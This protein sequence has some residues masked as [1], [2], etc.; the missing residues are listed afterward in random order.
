MA[1]PDYCPI[2]GEPCQ[3]L[4]ATPCTTNARI[5]ELEDESNKFRAQVS[6]L[7][8][9]RLGRIAELEAE[10]D[11]LRVDAE[12]YRWLRTCSWFDSPLCV[13]REPKRVLTSGIGLGADCPSDSRL[14]AAID[15]AMKG[16]PK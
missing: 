15:T 7:D 11:A 12:R 9:R 1:R 14:D 8:T 5:A 6:A 2:G 10:R 3:S 13:L 16:Q 4:C